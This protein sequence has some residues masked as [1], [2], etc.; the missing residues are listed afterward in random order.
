MDKDV[1]NNLI[2]GCIKNDRI[3]HKTIYNLFSR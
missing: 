1:L 3:A 2:D